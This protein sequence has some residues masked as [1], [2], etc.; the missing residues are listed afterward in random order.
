MRVQR[1]SD[2]PLRVRIVRGNVRQV[3]AAL[4]QARRR[5]MMR[6]VQVP[7]RRTPP[8]WLGAA[9]KWILKPWR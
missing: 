6:G 7:E 3:A 1:V 2:E 5:A 8:R 4:G 9:L